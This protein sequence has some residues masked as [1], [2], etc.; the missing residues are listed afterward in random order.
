[1]S[2][3]SHNKPAIQDPWQALRKHTPARIA[4]GRAGG[5][6]PTEQVLDFAQA[7]ALAR[8][9][10]HAR[11]DLPELSRA[12]APTAL[13][14]TTVR[15]AAPNRAAYLAR[16]DWGRRLHP[17][18]ELKPLAYAADIVVVICDGLSATA[19]Q[20]H[21]PL[22]MAQLLP[23]LTDCKFGPVV[24]A[25]QGRVAIADD[26]GERLGARLTINLIG[27]RPGLSAPDSLG[28]YLTYAPKRGNTDAQRNC[29]S[30]IRPQGLSYP[31]AAQQIAALTRHALHH[32]CS[33]VA[34]TSATLPA[35]PKND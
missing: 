34:L 26:I 11:L 17:D 6:L 1:M 28:A 33:G 20:R 2:D 19:V 13:P 7:H 12:L 15:S 10:V 3:A 8:D 25:E 14:I 27:E 32:A 35:L 21:A 16:P 5:S 9:A 4:L 24:I 29:I 22:L 30:N 18:V 31:Q 23:L